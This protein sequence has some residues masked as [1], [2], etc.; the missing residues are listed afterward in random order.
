MLFLLK[1]NMNR[2]SV[3]ESYTDK[4][5][6]LT[7]ENA[8]T[9]DEKKQVDD[10]LKKENIKKRWLK[11]LKNKDIGGFCITN[12]YLEKVRSIFQIAA[13]EEK[14]LTSLDTSKPSNV[15]I[16]S[17]DTRRDVP[18]VKEI[19][20]DSNSSKLSKSVNG[21]SCTVN[22]DRGKGKECNIRKGQEKAPQKEAEKKIE[23]KTESSVEEQYKKR[24][25]SIE[26]FKKTP[27][28]KEKSSS[29]RESSES[30]SERSPSASHTKR[31]TSH[32]SH[33]SYK[34]NKRINKMSS[35][36][37]ISER[38][39]SSVSE[40]KARQNGRGTK[41]KVKK[42][43]SESRSEDSASSV[44]EPSSVEDQLSDEESSP[45]KQNVKS[46]SSRNKKKE[47]SKSD[48]E[49]E[50]SALSAPSA[51]SNKSG[52]SD[53]ESEESVSDSNESDNP[54]DLYVRSPYSPP[55]SKRAR[56]IQEKSTRERSQET[57]HKKLNSDDNVR[58]RKFASS[59]SKR[60]S[61]MLSS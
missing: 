8:L 42:E 50:S 11:K 29:R 43:V 7:N 6:I 58:S 25:K 35:E 33:N 32:N 36:S 47:D 21:G 17:K 56:E 12:D 2:L 49:S 60:I 54:L 10:I 18:I 41:D 23:K 16:P 38:S 53:N 45:S 37:D 39:E 46:V 1:I 15:M 28:Y 22:D 44:E 3:L 26:N 27:I 61:K 9:E 4:S 52:D 5:F 40:Q 14:K 20:N 30:H 13:K 34:N 31:K 19:S 57:F 24:I 55:I 51:R 59:N 48:E